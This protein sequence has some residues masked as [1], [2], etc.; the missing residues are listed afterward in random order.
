[1]AYKSKKVKVQDEPSLERD[2]VSSAILNKDGQGY[3]MAVARSNAKVQEQQ[4][5]GSLEQE[6]ADLKAL[7]AD[8][9]AAK[10]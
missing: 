7:V 1:M 10:P 9:I 3:A 4:R 8:L 2:V 5:I 6:I